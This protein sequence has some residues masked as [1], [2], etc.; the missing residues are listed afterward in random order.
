MS[1]EKPLHAHVYNVVYSVM[2]ISGLTP[3]A[4][5]EN[6]NE[7]PGPVDIAYSPYSDTSSDSVLSSPATK[8]TFSVS[9]T[10]DYVTYQEV[11]T[12]QR[13]EFEAL[14]KRVY[15]T[16][17]NNFCLIAPIAHLLLAC[18]L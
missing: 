2:F 15:T 4:G 7:G 12:E 17:W 3:A 11:D 10:Y 14:L 5:R 1:A 6:H 18:K 16:F 13:I 8:R 9:Q